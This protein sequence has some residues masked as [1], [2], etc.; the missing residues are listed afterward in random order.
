[1]KNNLLFRFIIFFFFVVIILGWLKIFQLTSKM[2]TLQKEIAT[3][4][5]TASD[6]K[7][8]ADA[9][10]REWK[11]A[12]AELMKKRLIKSSN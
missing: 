5:E 12:Q 3:V 1:M 6:A 9:D 8:T 4:T 11:D 10:H 2:E 7:N